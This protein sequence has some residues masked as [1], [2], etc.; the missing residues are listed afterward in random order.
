VLLVQF[1]LLLANPSHFG[2]GKQA[3]SVQTHVGRRSYGDSPSWW[4][5]AQMDVFDV[6][7]DNVNGHTTDSDLHQY[8]D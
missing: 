5:N 7:E 1:V 4:V 2:D 3:H 8:S 6:L